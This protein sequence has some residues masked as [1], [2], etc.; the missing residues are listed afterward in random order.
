[1]QKLESDGLVFVHA[2]GTLVE[3]E[4]EAGEKLHVDT[5]IL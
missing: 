5:S 2:G 1:L 3:R 4:L